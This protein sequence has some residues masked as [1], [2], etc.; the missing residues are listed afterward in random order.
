MGAADKGVLGHRPY[1]RV[2]KS[3]LPAIPVNRF[4]LKLDTKTKQIKRAGVTFLKLAI[5]VTGRKS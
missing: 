1:K 5:W 3:P 4:S 2:A